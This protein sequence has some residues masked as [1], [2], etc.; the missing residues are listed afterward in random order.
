MA[1]GAG[2]KGHQTTTQ[3][4]LQRCA[5]N[6]DTNTGINTDTNTGTNSDTNTVSDTNGEGVASTPNNNT[7]YSQ[8]KTNTYT[9]TD[10]NT[11]IYITDNAQHT[12]KNTQYT[13]ELR[14]HVGWLAD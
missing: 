9:D 11:D 3:F 14:S 5:A 10:K 6:T 13:L 4:T 7:V 12:T 1:K 2:G 8:H